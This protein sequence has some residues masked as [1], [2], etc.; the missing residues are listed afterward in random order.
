MLSSGITKLSVFWV[1]EEFFLSCILNIKLINKK[2]VKKEFFC[3]S[4]RC[5]PK[6]IDNSL[7][8]INSSK[9]GVNDS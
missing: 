2:K 7:L 9:S 4:K 3:W 8:L 6:K 5:L 1:K